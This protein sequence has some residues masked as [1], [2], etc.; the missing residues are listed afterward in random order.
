MVVIA[1][2]GIMSVIAASNI[3]GK[4]PDYRLRSATR[5]IVSCLQEAKLR[6]VKENG[7]VVIVFNQNNES[8]KSFIDNIAGVDWSWDAIDTIVRQ[9]TLPSGI[10]IQSHPFTTSYTYGFNNNGLSAISGGTIQMKNTK[11]NYSRVVIN[12]A[13]NIR[14]ELSSD[15][16]NWD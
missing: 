11:S 16:I 13:G 3:I 6:A 15:G 9:V 10:D 1:I 4:L 7:R 14:T 8:Y 2:I 5:D 12:F